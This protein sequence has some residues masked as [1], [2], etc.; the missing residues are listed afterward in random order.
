MNDFQFV[1]Y[2]KYKGLEKKLTQT[3]NYSHLGQFTD[4]NLSVY[5]KQPF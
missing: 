5:L 4:M 2:S 3:S 1:S